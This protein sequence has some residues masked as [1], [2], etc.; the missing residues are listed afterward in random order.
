MNIE[1][2]Q[3]ELIDEFITGN[4]VF[5]I[6]SEDLNTGELREEGIV[7]TYDHYREK[8]RSHLYLPIIFFCDIYVQL[9][10]LHGCLNF[11]FGKPRER[12]FIFLW[13][14]IGEDLWGDWFT[15]HPYED[16]ILLGKNDKN[17][18]HHK[19]E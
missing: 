15:I 13:R 11:E 8:L 12:K 6:V 1:I 18:T 3:R 2:H 4:I 14:R 10:Y 16:R 17:L 9:A 5:R 19:G 7:T